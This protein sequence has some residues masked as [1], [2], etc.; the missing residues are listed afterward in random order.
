MSAGQWIQQITLGWLLYDLTNS[1]LLLGALNGLRSLPFLVF[2]PLAGVAADRMDRRQLML[3]TQAVLMC[4]ALGIWPSVALRIVQTSHLFLF[5][6]N[7]CGPRVRSVEGRFRADG[8][9][10]WK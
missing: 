10:R 2:G 7:G 1:P 8:V 5:T 9:G 4:T 3:I 6:L